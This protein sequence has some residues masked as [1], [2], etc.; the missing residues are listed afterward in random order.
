M[1]IFPVTRGEPVFAAKLK[2]TRQSDAL[3]AEKTAQASNAMQSQAIC[4]IL[5][6]V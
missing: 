4:K 1:L 6:V 2:K 5:Q 3:V